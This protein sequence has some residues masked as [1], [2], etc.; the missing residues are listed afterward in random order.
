MGALFSPPSRPSVT[1]PPPPAPPPTM[2]NSQIALTAANA[3][4]RAA[5]AADGTVATGPE[6]LKKPASTTKSTL[7]GG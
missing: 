1:M 3:S 4:R 5:A 2:A 6:G 7:L